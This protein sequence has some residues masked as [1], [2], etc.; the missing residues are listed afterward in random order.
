MDSGYIARESSEFERAY[1]QVLEN[2]IPVVVYF[3]MIGIT[4]VVGNLVTITFYWKDTRKAVNTFILGLAITDFC[5]SIVSFIGIAETVVNIKLESNFV[6]KT[7]FFLGYWFICLSISLILVIAIDRYRQICNPHR[8][9]T[10][11]AKKVIAVTA[12]VS[13]IASA[14]TF[15]WI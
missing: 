3:T 15:Q 2:F 14:H 5:V 13:M 4:G 12:T 6:C 10:T 9:K 11:K 7:S 1:R 8:E